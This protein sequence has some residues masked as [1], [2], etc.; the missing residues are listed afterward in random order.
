[1][2]QYK[3]YICVSGLYLDE[4]YDTLVGHYPMSDI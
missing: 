2:E 1:M 3:L 4:A